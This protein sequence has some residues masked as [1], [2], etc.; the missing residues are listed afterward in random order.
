MT[1]TQKLCYCIS[2][3]VFPW[4]KIFSLRNKKKKFRTQE[5]GGLVSMEGAALAYSC[6]LPN[7]SDYKYCKSALTWAVYRCII[8]VNPPLA[9]GPHI[10][11]F[12]IHSIIEKSNFQ[13]ILFEDTDFQRYIHGELPSPHFVKVKKNMSN[14]SSLAL[15]LTSPPSP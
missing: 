7:T 3:N 11:P 14:T 6:V 1:W 4:D 2:C 12:T 13:V 9:H 8:L 10:W 5:G 15:N